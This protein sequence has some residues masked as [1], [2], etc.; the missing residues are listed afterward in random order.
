MCVL[1]FSA[2]NIFLDISNCKCCISVLQEKR[3]NFAG[4]STKTIAK[5]V[6]F[7]A[8]LC[9][10]SALKYLRVGEFMLKPTQLYGFSLQAT[11]LLCSNLI[12]YDIAYKSCKFCCKFVAIHLSSINCVWQ[13]FVNALNAS[14][15]ASY[16][17]QV[18]ANFFYE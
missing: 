17:L 13:R 3:D 11:W 7:F 2:N 9:F 16:G 8:L 12:I 5:D 10:L 15:F 1:G 4:T 6:S 14:Q 18:A